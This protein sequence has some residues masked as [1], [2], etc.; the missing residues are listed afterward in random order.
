MKKFIY[1][2]KVL[3]YSDNIS[4]FTDKGK[5]YLFTQGRNIFSHTNTYTHIYEKKYYIVA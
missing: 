1:Q 2:E 5:K 4:A 3:Q